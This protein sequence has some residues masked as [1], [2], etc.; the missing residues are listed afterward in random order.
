M[1]SNLSTTLFPLP[2]DPPSSLRDR[3]GALLLQ[4]APSL[5]TLL[6]WCAVET[7]A[8]PHRS[9]PRGER[10]VVR[11][12]S[13]CAGVALAVLAWRVFE[14][15]G[16]DG[17]VDNAEEWQ[18]VAAG[19]ASVAGILLFMLSV[20]LPRT[21][22][23]IFY[24]LALGALAADWT[25]RQGWPASILSPAAAPFAAV[26]QLLCTQTVLALFFLT[27]HACRRATPARRRACP[28]PVELESQKHVDP[29]AF[30]W[31]WQRRSLGT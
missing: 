6:T 10:V 3:P 5:L 24:L 2:D 21:S 4:S 22:A 8:A 16:C 28:P 15:L 20:R 25:F 9:L 18:L 19:G 13:A 26:Q 12:V 17:L 27:P 31:W 23:A 29:D 30:F 11:L 14:L 7:F 1:C